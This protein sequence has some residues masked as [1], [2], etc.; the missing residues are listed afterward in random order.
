MAGG[1]RRRVSLHASRYA[2]STECRMETCSR[3]YLVR[4]EK[5][6]KYLE[7]VALPHMAQ[8]TGE[9]AGAGGQCVAVVFVWDVAAGGSQGSGRGRR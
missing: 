3:L 2:P 9:K 7:N 1:Y 8:K 4:K 6:E 5:N